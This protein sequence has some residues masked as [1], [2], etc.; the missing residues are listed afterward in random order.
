MENYLKSNEEN[1]KT[2]RETICKCQ[3][4]LGLMNDI[5]PQNQEVLAKS[6]R[7]NKNKF[8]FR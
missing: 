5:N 7:I 6:V 2:I 4:F 8:V 1:G 3:I